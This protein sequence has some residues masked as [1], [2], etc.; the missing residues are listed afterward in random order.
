MDD[1]PFKSFRLL[2]VVVFLVFSFRVL[3]RV[4]QTIRGGGVVALVVDYPSIYL[5][6]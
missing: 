6:R 3:P 4:K 1:A 5:A 2:P